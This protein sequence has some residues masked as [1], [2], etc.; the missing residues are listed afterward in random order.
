HSPVRIIWRQSVSHPWTAREG[1]RDIAVSA[2]ERLSCQSSPLAGDAP[3]VFHGGDATAISRSTFGSVDPLVPGST[4]SRL[5][6]LGTGRSVRARFARHRTGAARVAFFA[7]L[8]VL[9]AWD[10]RCPTEDEQSLEREF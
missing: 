6:L 8:V 5:N 3:P 1:A 7:S 9:Q 10:A 4:S 2:A